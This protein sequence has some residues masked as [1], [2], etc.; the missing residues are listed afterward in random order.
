MAPFEAV[1]T[2]L[3]WNNPL[4]GREVGVGAAAGVGDGLFVAVPVGA[5]VLLGPAATHPASIITI[6]A[7]AIATNPRATLRFIPEG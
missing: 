2:A 6:A 1:A 4:P 5:G 3:I 7:P